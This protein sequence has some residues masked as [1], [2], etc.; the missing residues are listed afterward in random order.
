MLC[1]TNNNSF[2]FAFTFNFYRKTTT[3]NNVRPNHHQRLCQDHHRV[4]RLRREQVSQLKMFAASLCVYFI[5]KGTAAAAAQ[6]SFLLLLR[7]LASYF[8]QQ[9]GVLVATPAARVCMLKEGR[10]RCWMYL[11]SSQIQHLFMAN[12][13]GCDH[14]T[15]MKIYPLCCPYLRTLHN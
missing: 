1:R 10:R 2:H 12:T 5:A 4:L 6:H 7:L 11:L 3:T 14:H 13:V 9:K 8:C 15:A